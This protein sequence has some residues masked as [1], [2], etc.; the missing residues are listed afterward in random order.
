MAQADANAASQL[1]NLQSGRSPTQA[2]DLARQRIEATRQAFRE[3]ETQLWRA[4]GA[5]GEG[6]MVPVD[7]LRARLRAYL[8]S[9]PKAYYNAMPEDVQAVFPGISAHRLIP[10]ASSSAS[11]DRLASDLLAKVPVR[12]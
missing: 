9:Q 1:H 5:D 11:R 12:N 6:A 7:P 3:Q 4:V 10:S 2:S 8:S